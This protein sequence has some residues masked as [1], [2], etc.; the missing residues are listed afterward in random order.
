M[1]LFSIHDSKAEAHL[2]PIAFKTA[3]E[4][5]RAFSSSCEDTSTNFYKYPSDYTLVEL[6]EFDEASASICTHASPRILSNASEFRR[7]Q[8]DLSAL[9][10]R[11]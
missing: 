4:A 8:P 7:K 3:A 2:P 9:E 10:E 5:I 11:N 1:K 6:G